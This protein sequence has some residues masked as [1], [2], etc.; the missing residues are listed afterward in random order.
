VYAA[1]G[2]YEAMVTASNDVSS[3]SATTTV[4]V[5]EAPPPPPELRG[6]WKLDET[7]G[8]R[9]DSSDYHNHL[10][11]HNTVGS[12]PGQD[13]LAADFEL[14]NTEYLAIDDGAQD[15]LDI[16]GSLTLVGWAKPESVNQKQVMAAKYEYGVSNRAYRIDLRLGNRIGFIVSPN[17]TYSGDYLLDVT[18]P[19]GL[20]ADTWYHVAGVF[21]AQAR[22]LSIYLDGDLVGTRSVSYDHIY[23]S[24][25]PFM[26]GADMQ[27]GS[28]VQPF[29][30]LL[31]EW[32]VY[33]RALDEG[34]VEDLMSSTP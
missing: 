29:D 22:T 11:D 9:L 27:S 18:A 19:G 3:Q 23:D 12:A 21:D 8:Q 15:G 5:E 20:S 14:S 17:G 6:H 16:T 34:E 25:A 24:S 10:T 4:V 26:L 31:D 30:G 28:V 32:R 7:A 2:E 33:G 1:A 13:G